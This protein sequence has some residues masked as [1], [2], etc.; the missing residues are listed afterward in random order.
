M[1]DTHR[2]VTRSQWLEARLQLLAAEKDLTRLRDQLS[3]RRRELP[4]VKVEQPYR[5][6]SERGPL[7]LAE[8]FGD[9]RQLLV[10]HL[11]F[12][13]DWDAACKSCSFWADGWTGILPHLAARDVS[14]AAIS[15]APLPKLQ[16][17]AKRLGWTFPWVSSGGS[18]F[19][20]DFGVSFDKATIERGEANYNY[21]KTAEVASDMP[22]VS[23]FYKGDDGAVYHTYSTFE[24]GIDALNPAYQYLDLTPKGRDEAGLAHSMSWVKR[25]DEY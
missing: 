4:W 15:R 19:N 24:R 16:A 9:K 13:P 18:D 12:A 22:G 7:S 6:D 8:L 10:Y 17:Y 14:F 25:H 20:F 1:S 3:Q 21:R 11:M 5:F 23:V 2:I